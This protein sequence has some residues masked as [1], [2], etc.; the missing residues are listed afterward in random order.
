[1]HRFSL[2]RKA[3]GLPDLEYRATS[4]PFELKAE[5]D[6]PADWEVSGY[7][8]VF[9][10]TP[11][12]FGDTI[13]KGAFADSLSERPVKLFYEHRDLIGVPL[14]VKE[15]AH[16]LFGRWRILPT[17]IGTDA[18]TLAV[19]GALDRLSI[20]FR[21][22]EWN[23]RDDGGRHLVK[24]DLYETS[25][26]AF[27]AKESAVITGV[28]HGGPVCTLGDPDAKDDGPC[29]GCVAPEQ[30]ATWTAAFINGLPDS[31]F[32]VIEPGGTKDDEGKTTPRRLRHL[33]HHD[34]GG[35]L[36]TPHLRNALSRLPQT[37]LS[38][39]LKQR[40]QAHL[41]KHASSAGMGKSEGYVPDHEGEV[42]ALQYRAHAENVLEVSTPFLARSLE[43]AAS[44][45][46]AGRLLSPAHYQRFE[47]LRAGFDAL[48]SGRE[49]G[50]NP[51]LALEL[52]RRRL[53]LAGI[54]T[55]DEGH[56]S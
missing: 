14:E 3:A 1:M 31:S 5:G 52:R 26:V 46:D 49:S 30:R 48:L 47:E 8:S 16:G 53:R 42:D 28:K 23:E 24:I 4:A 51:N 29:M 22:R 50:A 20:G 27:P 41:D 7:A 37:K 25:L 32:A 45:A 56:Q 54:L 35:K 43:L 33:P 44:R 2:E 17:S 36:D 39:S 15:D 34:D 19:Q 55:D 21:A 12:T 10:D 11:D 13:A 9:D 6:S 40:A 18:H 38:D